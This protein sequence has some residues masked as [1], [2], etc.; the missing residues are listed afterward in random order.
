[1]CLKDQSL[2]P[3]LFRLFIGDHNH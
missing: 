2:L 1:M 3:V